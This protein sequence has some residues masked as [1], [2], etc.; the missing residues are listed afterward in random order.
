[1]KASFIC[2]LES[3]SL[4]HLVP[5][6]SR[7]ASLTAFCWKFWRKR[8][9]PYRHRSRAT[10]DQADQ[11]ASA[12]RRGS[13]RGVRLDVTQDERERRILLASEVGEFLI[14]QRDVGNDAV[15][16]VA[17]QSDGREHLRPCHVAGD[18]AVLQR[19]SVRAA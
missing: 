16:V 1:M 9:R 8:G 3:L 15:L 11:R 2:F 6:A 12:L 18:P 17:R 19:E 7:P 13:R 10:V 4:S 5:Q 14:V